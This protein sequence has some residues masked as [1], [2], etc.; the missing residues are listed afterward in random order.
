MEV[1]LSPE[2]SAIVRRCIQSGRYRTAEDVVAAALSRV[3]GRNEGDGDIQ[4][5]AAV[6][7]GLEQV[8]IDRGGFISVDDI[9]RRALSRE[10]AA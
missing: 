8:C 3:E 4:L 9:R 2:S 10:R 6:K 5:V 1:R 7:I